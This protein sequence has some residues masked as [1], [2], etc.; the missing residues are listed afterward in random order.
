MT[1]AGGGNTGVT[2]GYFRLRPTST[3]YLSC[4][5]K[6]ACYGN[7]KNGTYYNFTQ[8]HEDFEEI[9]AIDVFQEG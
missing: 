4:N 5:P 6:Q 8:C 2:Y 3:I 7:F 1:C 9:F